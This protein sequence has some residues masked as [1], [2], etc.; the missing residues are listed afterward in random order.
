MPEALVKAKEWLV[1]LVGIACSTSICYFYFL[2]V[3]HIYVINCTC[4]QLLVDLIKK[5]GRAHV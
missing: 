5:I 1:D 2:L 3:L 4:A